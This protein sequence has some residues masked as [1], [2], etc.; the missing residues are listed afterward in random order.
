MSII[1]MVHNTHNAVVVRS[2][3]MSVL[4]IFSS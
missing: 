4:F 1:G 2:G 3:C